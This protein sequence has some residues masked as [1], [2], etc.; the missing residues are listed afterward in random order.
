MKTPREKNPILTLR[1]TLKRF[2]AEYRNF[3]MAT[4]L[5]ADYCIT[6]EGL[7]A[8]TESTLKRKESK[9]RLT[10]IIRSGKDAEEALLASP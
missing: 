8:L 2:I 9:S 10:F 1:D 4:Q 5:S 7:G 6:A 3:D